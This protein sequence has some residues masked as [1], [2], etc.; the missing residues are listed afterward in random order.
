MA[1]LMRQAIEMGHAVKWAAGMKLF[2]SLRDLIDSAGSER[3]FV[4]TL[5]RPSVLAI[6][7]VL[8]PSGSLTDFQRAKLMEII[9]ERYS[10]SRPT[11]LTLNIANR[12]EADARIGVAIAERLIDGSLCV[13]FDVPSFR[14]GLR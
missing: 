2:A 9:D 6:S 4:S 8:P 3:S 10:A 13:A 7:D 14:K 12:A 11:W 5:T 1:A